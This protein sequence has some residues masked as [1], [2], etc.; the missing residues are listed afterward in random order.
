MKENTLA[1]SYVQRPPSL[2]DP[3]FNPE[4]ERMALLKV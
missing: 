2:C 1:L 4:P 3:N